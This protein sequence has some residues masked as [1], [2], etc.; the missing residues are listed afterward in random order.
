M[1]TVIKMK[2]LLAEKCTPEQSAG[3]AST[4]QISTCAG[5][6]R[7][8]GHCHCDVPACLLRGNRRAST[9]LRTQNIFNTLFWL[10]Q[11]K[12]WASLQPICSR[13]TT[14]KR[15]PC[16]SFMYLTVIRNE[17]ILILSPWAPNRNERHMSLLRMLFCS[18]HFQRLLEIRMLSRQLLCAAMFCPACLPCCP[19]VAMFK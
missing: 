2:Q 13:R 8:I 14:L 9:W 6:T 15:R 12:L 17:G 18:T 16:S 4:V 11:P 19:E 5:D 10:A 1:E 3:Y 7:L